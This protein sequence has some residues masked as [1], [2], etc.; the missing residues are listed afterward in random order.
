MHINTY[1]FMAA[2]NDFNEED[3]KRPFKLAVINSSYTSGRPQVTFD[4]EST[5]SV[6]QYPYLNSYTPAASERVLLASVGKG[7]VI[8]GSVL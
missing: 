3:V 5:L 2:I 8:L 1:D 6:K 7:W 4:G